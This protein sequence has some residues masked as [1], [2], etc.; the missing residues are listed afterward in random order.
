MLDT[1]VREELIRTGVAKMINRV[2]FADVVQPK[3][4]ILNP[5]ISDH[6]QKISHGRHVLSPSAERERSANHVRQFTVLKKC[7]F[8]MLELEQNRRGVDGIKYKAI[9]RVREDVILSQS[10]DKSL[11]VLKENA[12]VTSSC[13]NWKGINDKIAVVDRVA[14]RNYFIGPL[15]VYYGSLKP[16][17]EVVNPETFLQE[18]Y[19]QKGLD[20]I[21]EDSLVVLLYVFARTASTVVFV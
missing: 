4:P 7:Y 9:V 1:Q 19:R 14:A 10:L 3:R 17:P 11:N 15:E 5:V 12:I 6:V 2:V 13:A 20:L 21:Q 16:Y 8:K 18:T